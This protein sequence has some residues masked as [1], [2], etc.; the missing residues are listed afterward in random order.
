MTLQ[1]LPLNRFGVRSAIEVLMAEVVGYHHTSSTYNSFRGPCS[2]NFWMLLP[3]WTP[4]FVLVTLNQPT[5]RSLPF[6]RWNINTTNLAETTHPSP[7][8]I[9]IIYPTLTVTW[10]WN[11]NM[12]NRN[13]IDSNAFH[14][15]VVS[16]T[17][18][19]CSPI[20]LTANAAEHRP[21]QKETNLPTILFPVL[22]ECFQI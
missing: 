3:A 20:K 5:M 4:K 13:C 8:T 1:D 7:F 17:E 11:I 21:S 18:G 6:G 10:Q 19:N 14:D 9:K 15:H 16:F 2:S 12:F 22:C